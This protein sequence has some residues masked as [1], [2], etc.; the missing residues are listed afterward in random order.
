MGMM[1]GLIWR[2]DRWSSEK[3][4][5]I[6]WTCAAMQTTLV[7]KGK[8]H[9]CGYGRWLK[10]VRP[11]RPGFHCP[12]RSRRCAADLPPR[13][14]SGL[15]GSLRCGRW[16][17]RDST[18]TGL[19]KPTFPKRFCRPLMIARETVVLPMCCRVAATKI[20]RLKDIVSAPK[21]PGGGPLARPPCL[22]SGSGDVGRSRN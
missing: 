16:W 13:H 3:Y 15:V 20:G 19:M 4:S 18:P 22:S 1:T 2:Y 17:Q 21:R 10:A 9:A 14:T 12:R 5:F 11:Y 6:T 7:A 8:S